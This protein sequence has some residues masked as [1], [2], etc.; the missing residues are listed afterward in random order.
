MEKKIPACGDRLISRFGKQNLG[1][2]LSLQTHFSVEEYCKRI[3]GDK[4][5][6]SIDLFLNFELNR[7]FFIDLF[8]LRRKGGARVAANQLLIHTHL[9]DADQEA[10]AADESRI[11]TAIGFELLGANC[12]DSITFTLPIHVRYHI[13][14]RS[15]Y[16]SSKVL[17]SYPSI[18][19][20]SSSRFNQGATSIPSISDSSY[21]QLNSY[22][23]NFNDLY[24][25]F[26]GYDKCKFVD[27]AANVSVRI[28]IATLSD[29]YFVTWTTYA[30]IA[31]STVVVVIVIMRF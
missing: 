7:G 25:I 11:H 16:S 13:A 27:S 3:R 5:N 4:S 8:E 10:M 14:A 28:P 24:L 23:S 12:S 31:W 15:R 26:R 29:T 21:L 30:V 20:R 19:I 1:M 6:K 17:I 22:S 9:L 2:H 18:Y